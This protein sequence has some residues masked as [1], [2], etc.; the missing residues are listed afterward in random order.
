MSLKLQR[1]AC[2]VSISKASIR[3]PLLPPW[4]RSFVWQDVIPAYKLRSWCLPAKRA[5]R[6]PMS[7]GGTHTWVVWDFAQLDKAQDKLLQIPTLQSLP[8]PSSCEDTDL[9][10]VT[11]KSH[12]TC[13]DCEV[14]QDT[15]KNS[16]QEARS[17]HFSPVLQPEMGGSR[18]L[19][20][21][22]HFLENPWK[23]LLL[24]L[25][26]LHQQHQPGAYLKCRLSTFAAQRNEQCYKLTILQWNL[27]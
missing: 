5:G 8:S 19:S 25:W 20:C 7:Q 6:P 24:K 12:S 10:P 17:Q 15:G 18:F 13:S 21:L 9:V 11:H 27:F 14:G 26:S 2:C 3:L 1:H 4:Q 23:L 22:P 16:G